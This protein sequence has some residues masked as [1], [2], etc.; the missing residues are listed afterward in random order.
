MHTHTHIYI[1]YIQSRVLGVYNVRAADFDLLIDDVQVQGIYTYMH[2]HTSRHEGCFSC[3]PA[4]GISIQYLH[5]SWYEWISPP[6]SWSASSGWLIHSY[7]LIHSYHQPEIPFQVAT[8]SQIFFS[9][10]ERLQSALNDTSRTCPQFA[11]PHSQC[12]TA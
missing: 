3:H 10:G 12:S 2:T 4:P 7:Q 9:G 8:T 11:W 1:L 6:F 5:P